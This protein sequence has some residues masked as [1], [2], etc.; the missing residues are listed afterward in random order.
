[1]GGEITVE[2]QFGKGSTFVMRLPANVQDVVGR[3][4]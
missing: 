3:Q 1:M 2:S 4:D